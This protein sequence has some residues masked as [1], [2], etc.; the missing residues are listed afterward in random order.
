M[1]NRRQAL[2]DHVT[3]WSF[4][5]VAGSSTKRAE[6]ARYR[7]ANAETRTRHPRAVY[8]IYRDKLNP[9]PFLT[10][11]RQDAG[12]LGSTSVAVKGRTPAN[13]CS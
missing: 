2:S 4:H 6:V 12:S 3:S 10:S 1:G 5:R 9:L 13:L 8:D 11:C 7:K